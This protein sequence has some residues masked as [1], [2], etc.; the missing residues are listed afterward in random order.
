MAASKVYTASDPVNAEI[1]KDYLAGH[2]IEAEVR[3]HFLWGGMGDLPANVY[4]TVWVQHSEQ[5]ANARKL[6]A[7]FEAGRTRSGPDWR[8]AGCGERLASQFT[9]C[10]QCGA[11]RSDR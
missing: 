10:W 6:L 2:G 1:V 8:C 4:P 5:H 9:A 3:D 11:A 7:D